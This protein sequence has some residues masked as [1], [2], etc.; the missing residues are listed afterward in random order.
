MIERVIDTMPEGVTR[1]NIV[2]D[3]TNASSVNFGGRTARACIETIQNHYPGR[4]AKLMYYNTPL[5]FRVAYKATVGDAF[6]DKIKKRIILNCTTSNLLEHFSAESLLSDFG[7]KC[8][9]NFRNWIRGR[10]TSEGLRLSKADKLLG[11]KATTMTNGAPRGS[12]IDDALVE[13][14][15]DKAVREIFS[16]TKR[17]FMTKQGGI[18]KNWNK[19]F[20]VLSGPLLYYYKD[21]LSDK[22][23]GCVVLEDA[24]VFCD[25]PDGESTMFFISTPNRK[26]KFKA[27]TP[28]EKL[29]W[30]RALRNA[31]MYNLS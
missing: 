20:C 24:A 21:E 8:T 14:L 15:K 28:V 22:P 31:W 7:G 11:E 18:L 6:G 27:E 23:Q 4:V 26:W 16:T 9:Y 2:Q 1:F 17:G 25:D 30:M 10:Y 12:D 29:A 5:V 19:R 13:A 3:W